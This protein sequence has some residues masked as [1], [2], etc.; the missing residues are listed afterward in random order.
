MKKLFLLTTVSF[1][2]NHLVPDQQK[3]IQLYDGIAPGSESWNWNEAEN[4]KNMWQTKVVYNV[5]KPTLNV[6][7]PEANTGNGTAVII[8]PGGAF[9]ALSINSEGYDV[10]KWLVKKGVTCFVLKY[11]L[12]HSLTDDPTAE[13]A[14]KMGKKEFEEL[15]MAEP[16][17]RMSANMLLNMVLLLNASAL[18]V[19]LQVELWRLLPHLIILK[20]TVLILWLRFIP[21]S[22]PPCTELL[23]MMHRR[24]LL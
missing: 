20:I 21:T 7:L 4:D 8:C 13:V 15:L 22:L 23:P 11:R 14:S 17:S 16:L 9:Y 19:F 12:A 1:L 18:W 2:L 5:T 3:V 24:Y 6:F 10:A